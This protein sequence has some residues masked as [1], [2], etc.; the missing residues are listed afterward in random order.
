MKNKIK[1]CRPH[2]TE[3]QQTLEIGRN[4]AEIKVTELDLCIIY[5]QFKLYLLL[6]LAFRHIPSVDDNIR[7]MRE[8]E[9]TFKRNISCLKTSLNA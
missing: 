5:K 2:C 9:Y 4:C 7:A 6:Y 8:K 3:H 1:N